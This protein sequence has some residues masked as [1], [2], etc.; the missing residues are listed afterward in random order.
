MAQSRA[1]TLGTQENVEQQY[2]HAFLSKAEKAHGTG[3]RIE[4][5]H[6]KGARVVIVDDVCTTGGSTI[7]AMEAAR[8]YG[9][10]LG[11]NHVPG[12]ASGIPGPSGH[13]KSRGNG[14]VRLS[15]H[16]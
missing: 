12:R 2:I 13:R 4:G 1:Q 11:E 8:E 3:R 16:G 7:Q 6:T 14:A 15:V 10:E 9:F 5:F